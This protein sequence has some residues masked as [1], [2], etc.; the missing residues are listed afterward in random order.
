MH[1]LGAA[2]EDDAARARRRGCLG[3]SMSQGMD[4]AID[5]GLAH[6]PGDELGVLGAEVQDQDTTGRQIAPD[7]FTGRCHCCIHRHGLRQLSIR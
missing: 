4:L 3:R 6:A 2:G 7:G 1:R 5:P